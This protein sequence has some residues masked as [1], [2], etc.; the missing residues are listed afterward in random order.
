M[1]VISPTIQVPHTMQL[2][3]IKIAI[4]SVLSRSKVGTFKP[5]PLILDRSWRDRVIFPTGAVSGGLTTGHRSLHKLP[6]FNARTSENVLRHVDRASQHHQVQPL[7]A[8]RSPL[9][10][11]VQ[12]TSDSANGERSIIDSDVIKVAADFIVE[13]SYEI[14]GEL[15]V[16]DG[17]SVTV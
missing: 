16:E 4:Q 11:Q 1:T 6:S 5:S 13:D 9:S 10:R 14:D 8:N 7:G 12:S 17:G 2:T 15:E 3:R